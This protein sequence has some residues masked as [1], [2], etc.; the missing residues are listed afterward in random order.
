[1]LNSVKPVIVENQPPI[2][3]FTVPSYFQAAY[4]DLAFPYILP[5]HHHLSHRDDPIQGAALLWLV[6]STN[7]AYMSILL[8]RVP[9]ALCSFGTKTAL[10]LVQVVLLFC[11]FRRTA[12]M[13]IGALCRGTCDLL[14][15][16][17]V[18]GLEPA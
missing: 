9:R 7:V 2:F 6:S 18:A 1:M 5:P 12:A 15:L 17:E 11:I 3:G 4:H 16:F 10:Y 8:D 14:H 13:Y